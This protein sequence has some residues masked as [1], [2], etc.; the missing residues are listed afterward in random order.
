MIVKILRRL[1]GILDVLGKIG[2]KRYLI[3]K[4]EGVHYARYQIFN[5]KWLTNLKI[6]NVLDVG[7][8]VGE[9]TL[10][11]HYLFD[12]PTIHSF[13][14]L[15]SCKGKLEAIANNKANVT[16]H[17]YA[18]GA[19]ESTEIL[20]VS[21]HAPS[22]SILNMGQLHKTD[23]P[24]SAGSSDVEIR[25]KTLD[26]V[27][28]DVEFHGN[29]LIKMDVQGFELEVIQGG[30]N[31]FR[32]AKVVVLEMSIQELYEEEPGFDDLYCILKSLGFTYHGSLKQSVS[33]SDESFLQCDGI[34][35]NHN[36]S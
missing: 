7:A 9:F 33:K 4:K 24:H 23:Y 13:E 17:P 29:L 21:S 10:V 16:F 14:P 6:R 15:P 8:N 1:T 26:S 35:I 11:F 28:G 19:R 3:L 18:L 25:C 22:S 12:G 34:F 32:L 36:L 5:R 30:Y 20:H 2:P 27:L 31:V